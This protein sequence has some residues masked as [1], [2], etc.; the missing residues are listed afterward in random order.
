MFA[1]SS[2]QSCVE[3]PAN[4]TPNVE[5]GPASDS[6]GESSAEKAKGNQL[7]DAFNLLQA[8][9]AACGYSLDPNLPKIAVVGPE[10]SGKSSV[11]QSFV[12]KDFLPSGSGLVTR[13][14]TIIQLE[15]LPK[16]SEE[17]GVF[18]HV[19]KGDDNA[20][21]RFYNFEAIRQEIADETNRLL[22]PTEFSSEPIVLKIFSPHVL[23]LT[24]VDLP[25]MVENKVDDQDESVVSNVKQMVRENIADPGTLILAVCPA[26]QPIATA[27]ALKVA[28]EVDP[29][30]ERTIGV[31][32]KLDLEEAG[33]NSVDVLENRKLPLQ[34]GYVGVVNR[35]KMDIMNGRDRAHERKYEK[36]FFQNSCYS[37]LASRMG[38]DY[39]QELLQKTLKQHIQKQ[40]PSIRS[41]LSLRLARIQ[42][43]LK[44]FNETF[45]DSLDEEDN[46]YL[47]NY[48]QDFIDNVNVDLM[49]Y[50]DEVPDSTLSTGA[51]L[52][53]LLNFEAQ[54]FLNL[55]T[56]PDEK[57]VTCIVESMS[58]YRN[59]ISLPSLSMNAIC[60]KLVNRFIDP[61][62]TSL[63]TIKDVLLDSACSGTC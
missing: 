24:L 61:L 3:E 32:T 55:D 30:R 54:K 19:P 16:G 34:R 11:L 35:S 2:S 52:N 22:G 27:V 43:E 18:A 28:E 50:S 20:E 60:R 4:S 29:K 41:D 37:Y 8:K 23:K 5:N 56:T 44:T 62:E 15:P 9:M 59:S 38:S 48:V 49:G 31:L 63:L 25:G 40:L 51:E 39:L 21:K 1:A 53:F 17:Y 6:Q 7:L 14:P 12:G 13:R 58:G 47:M 46:F 33:T 10:N 45:G 36:K 42:R 26:N 57:N